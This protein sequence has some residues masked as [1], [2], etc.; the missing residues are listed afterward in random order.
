MDTPTSKH[1]KAKRPKIVQVLT[2]TDGR[3]AAIQYDNGRVFIWK[4]QKAPNPFG[5]T[6]EGYW[7]DIGFRTTKVENQKS[8]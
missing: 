6:E 5:D 7:A 8:E 3:I 1:K 2:A 4:D